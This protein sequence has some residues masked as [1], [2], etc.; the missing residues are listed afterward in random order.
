MQF[1]VSVDTEDGTYRCVVVASNEFYAEK[2]AMKF[3][4]DDGAEV[5]GADAEMFNTFEHGDPS[6]YEVLWLLY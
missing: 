2:K 3:Y 5:Y 4:E 1:L 6:D